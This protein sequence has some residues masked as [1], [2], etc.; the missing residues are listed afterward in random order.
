M[1]IHRKKLRRR[2]NSRGR[3]EENKRESRDEFKESHKGEREAEGALE[4]E[5]R[6]GACKG[7]EGLGKMEGER[8]SL[9]GGREI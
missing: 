6:Y 3:E 2:K 4:L 7:R 5:G 8:R 9:T 1:R